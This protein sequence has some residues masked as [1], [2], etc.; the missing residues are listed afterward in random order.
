MTP[1]QQ[2]LRPLAL[3]EIPK[4]ELN[5]LL[6]AETSVDAMNRLCYNSI[7]TPEMHHDSKRQRTSESSQVSDV[8]FVHTLCSTHVIFA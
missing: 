7:S 4:E 1:R 8:S 3:E 6:Y 5:A 2:P